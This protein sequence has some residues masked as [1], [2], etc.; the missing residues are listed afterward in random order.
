MLNKVTMERVVNPENMKAAYLAVKANRGSSGVDGMEV[1]EMEKHLRQHWES[2]RS[3][4]NSPAEWGGYNDRDVGT[5]VR[6]GKFTAFG[7]APSSKPNK[8]SCLS[9]GN[10][11]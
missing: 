9:L 3:K 10:C 5:S 11:E 7:H 4:E 1:Q 8:S 6:R 2:I